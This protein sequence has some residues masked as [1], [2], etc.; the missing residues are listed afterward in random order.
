M[1]NL[2]SKKTVKKPSVKKK[3]VI[4]VKYDCGLHNH[5][6]IRGEGA[7]LSWH[8]GTPL[9][10]IKSDEWKFDIDA[11][12]EKIEFKILINDQ[13]FEIGENRKVEK[14]ETVKVVPKFH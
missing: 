2:S 1:K 7:G 6:T 12:D 9:K 13:V 5:L 8:H 10:N 3:T 4:V 11:P 14:G